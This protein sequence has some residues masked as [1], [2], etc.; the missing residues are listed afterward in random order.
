MWKRWLRYVRNFFGFSH[1][2]AR[3]FIVLAFLLL[4]VYGGLLIYRLLPAERY[5]P[6]A[7]QQQLDSLIA[8]LDA[9]DTTSSEQGDAAY[10]VTGVAG[11]QLFAFNPNTVSQDSLLALGFPSYLARRLIN[12][13]SKG[14]QFRKKEDLQKLY[15]LPPELYQRLEPYIF[16]PQRPQQERV[17]AAREK[18]EFPGPAPPPSSSRFDLNTADSLQL[19]SVRGIG[20]ALSSRILKFR[21]GLGG[22]ASAAQVR[23]VYGLPPEAADALL[24]RAYVD[25]APALRPLLINQADAFQLASHPYISRKQAALIV[26]YRAQH[27]NYT[28]AEELLNIH[29]L[30]QQFVQKVAPYLSFEAP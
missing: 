15:G 13:R 7:D 27:G 10:P 6:L 25:E 1:T 23:E 11:Q 16:I 3:S 8:Q 21:S 2:E 4:L 29:T 28:G 22:F 30:D 20:P 19:L 5:H 18:R 9:F 24:E 12:Y 14:G 17:Y 26:A